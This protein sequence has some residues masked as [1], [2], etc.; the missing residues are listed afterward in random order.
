[1]L[2][3]VGLK[4]KVGNYACAANGGTCNIEQQVVGVDLAAFHFLVLLLSYVCDIGER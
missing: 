1:M 2:V 4:P 3:N